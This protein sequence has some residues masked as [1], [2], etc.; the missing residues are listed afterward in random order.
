MILQEL[1]RITIST[2]I[3]PW[4]NILR[5]D[6][7]GE[8]YL[9]LCTPVHRHVS[10]TDWVETAVW[11]MPLSKKNLFFFCRR[12][13]RAWQHENVV[14]N[15][16]RLIWLSSFCEDGDLLIVSENTRGAMDV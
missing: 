11:L 7:D 16:N 14:V 4:R 5:G 13:Q 9:L 6:S 3:S 10:S 12:E 2:I 1:N 8:K 15:L